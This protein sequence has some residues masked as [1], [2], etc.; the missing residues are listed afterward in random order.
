MSRAR[1]KGEIGGWRGV[2]FS[3]VDVESRTEAGSCAN[4]MH[5]LIRT[6]MILVQ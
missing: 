2:G 6:E 1:V 5:C 4:I 3:A